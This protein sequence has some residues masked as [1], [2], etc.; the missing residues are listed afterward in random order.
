MQGKILGMFTRFIRK[1]EFP[2]A[3]LTSKMIL[4]PKVVATLHFVGSEECFCAINLN[5]RN[6]LHRCIKRHRKIAHHLTARFRC[7]LILSYYKLLTDIRYS[8]YKSRLIYALP[9]LLL[10]PL[11]V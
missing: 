5:P 10:L 4:L 1:G 8:R 9:W 3:Q 2:A 7:L 11:C 6:A